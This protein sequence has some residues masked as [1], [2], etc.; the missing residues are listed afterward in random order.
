M[1][2]SKVHGAGVGAEICRIARTLACWCLSQRKTLL[3]EGERRR[4]NI[5][6]TICAYVSHDNS[7]SAFEKRNSLRTV[8]GTK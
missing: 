5:F 2:W 8:P 4:E 3:F 1:S 7:L 6:S